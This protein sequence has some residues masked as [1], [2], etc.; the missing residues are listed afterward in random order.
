MKLLL[1]QF[2]YCNVSYP[3]ERSLAKDNVIMIGHTGI[4]PYCGREFSADKGA[5]SHAN[6]VI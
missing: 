6:C 1:R 5:I 2:S 3:R 4:C